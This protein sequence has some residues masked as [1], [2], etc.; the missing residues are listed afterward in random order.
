MAKILKESKG[1]SS[2]GRV[3][4]DT[5]RRGSKVQRGSGEGAIALDG[6]GLCRHG[7]GEVKRECMS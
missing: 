5:R 2:E 3:W 6:C 1:S 4:I 7:I